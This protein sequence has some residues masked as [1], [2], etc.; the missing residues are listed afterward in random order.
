MSKISGKTST[1]A[2]NRYN[3]VVYSRY[4]FI[5]GKGTI[6][7]AIIQKYKSTKDN[8]FSELIKLCLCEHFGL[9]RFKGDEICV[10][11]H[12]IDGKH[13]KNDE[14][15]KYFQPKIPPPT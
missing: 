14:I 2:K 8:N 6:L 7:D 5:V 11:E 10:E 9:S 3:K 15:E 4:N 12:I 13:I 1:A